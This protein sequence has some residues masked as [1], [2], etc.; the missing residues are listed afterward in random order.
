MDFSKILIRPVITE[1]SMDDANAGKFTFIVG[2]FAAKT[3][4]RKAIQDRF[5]V[6]VEKIMTSVIKGKSRRVGIRRLEVKIQP[7]KKAVVELKKGQKIDIF[8]I[9]G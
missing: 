8:E 1:K 9:G 7:I 2:R 6:N 5:K 4:I 3:Q